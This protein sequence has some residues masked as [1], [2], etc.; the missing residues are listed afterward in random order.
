[1]SSLRGSLRKVDIYS[2]ALGKATAL[3]NLSLY[4]IQHQCIPSKWPFPR[5]T[6]TH[7]IT[8]TA[9]YKPCSIFHLPALESQ[10]HIQLGACFDVRV[11][12]GLAMD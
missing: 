11:G 12:K 5:T 2:Y 9:R 10:A 3:A 6:L 1:V 8:C 7:L 4:L